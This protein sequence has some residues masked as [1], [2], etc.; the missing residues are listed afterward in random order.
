MAA[1]RELLPFR[2]REA[3]LRLRDLEGKKDRVNRLVLRSQALAERRRLLTLE[4]VPP[5][6]VQFV[7]G[8]VECS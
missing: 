8:V 1:L 7:V 4:P 5:D 6:N 3:L 2:C